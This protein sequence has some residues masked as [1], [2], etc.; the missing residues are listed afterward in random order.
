[1]RLLRVLGDPRR[2][3]LGV[4]G[5]GFLA[6][7]PGV[8]LAA[9]AG[10]VVAA[11]RAVARP[12]AR[13]A[14]LLLGGWA[15]TFLVGAAL[16]EARPLRYFV[17]L[18]PPL[19]AFAGLLLAALVTP[20]RAGAAAGG[21]ACALAGVAA[22][23]GAAHA[24]ELALG[25]RSL[26]PLA[27][28]ASAGG[29][30]GA[31]AAGRRRPWRASPG[32]RLGGAV[33]VGL[34]TIGHGAL[35][36]TLDLVHA[37]R[38][39]AVANGAAA[40]ALGPHAV[41]AGPDAQVLAFG[42]GIARLRAPWIDA[43][44]GAVDATLR[45][46]RAEGVT[47]IALEDEQARSSDLRAAFASRGARTALVGIF[48]PAGKPVLLLR[49]PWAEAAGYAPSAFERR[50]AADLDAPPDAPD[51]PLDPEVDPPLLLARVRALAHER[52]GLRARA[53]ARRSLGSIARS[54]AAREDPEAPSSIARQLSEA[55]DSGGLR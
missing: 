54:D 19:A 18:G 30:V 20:G 2:E 45:R 4:S 5:S 41:V 38:S 36:A 25:P 32:L 8:V 12:G 6:L 10:G 13:D 51:A 9:A 52:R 11:R 28:A 7:A 29:L 21:V 16:L 34:V 47:H 17:V 3:G 40:L 22:A 15:L 43:S 1:V 24:L 44:P 26:G 50:R 37:A 33:I 14:A 53:L 42:H 23:L 35:E 55:I 49:L 39:V 31:L 48:L 27:I 46:L